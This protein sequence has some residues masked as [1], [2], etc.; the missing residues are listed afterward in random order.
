MLTTLT[1]AAM[2]GPGLTAPQ[3][4]NAIALG[5]GALGRQTA[6]LLERGA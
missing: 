4:F 1:V 3:G 5:S 6:A 2:A